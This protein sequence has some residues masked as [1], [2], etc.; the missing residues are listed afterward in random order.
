MLSK[1]DGCSTQGA[2]DQNDWISVCGDGVIDF[3]NPDGQE[4][5]EAAIRNTIEYLRTLL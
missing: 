5:F 1:T 3:D 2:P 4:E